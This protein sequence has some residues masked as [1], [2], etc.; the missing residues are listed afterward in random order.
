MAKFNL[1][2]SIYAFYTDDLSRDEFES[3]IRSEAPEVYSFYVKDMKTHKNHSNRLMRGLAFI[4]NLFIAFLLKMSPARRLIYSLIIISFFY[5][6]FS[7][8]WNLA[9]LAF[10]M[11]NVL[12]AFEIAGKLSAK[13]ELDIARK[14]QISLMPEKAPEL[15][16][17]D[18]A[19]HAETAREVGGDYVDFLYPQNGNGKI[20]LIIGDIS[21]KGMGAAIQMVQVQALIHNLID[22]HDEMKEVF[23]ALNRNLNKILQPG[24]FFTTSIASLH[25][26]GD[27][28]ICRAGHTSIIHYDAQKDE[29]IP[30]VPKGIGMG[31]RDKGIFEK[32]LE[33]TICKP[34]PGDVYVFYTDGIT[35]MMNANNVEFGE[36]RLQKT[37]CNH[38]HKSAKEIKNAILRNLGRFADMKS[39]HDDLTMIVVKITETNTPAKVV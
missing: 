39:P 20:Y 10:L 8:D 6:S 3:L 7:N 2:K 1:F 19:F 21:G 30:L 27:I 36:K 24:N 22:R 37:V 13:S 12:L 16:H 31:L 34:H 18:I 4:K 32:T 33:E 15:E 26:S 28:S 14:I 17:F 35:E 11:L 25:T 23:F 29:C 5:A 38:A 9:T